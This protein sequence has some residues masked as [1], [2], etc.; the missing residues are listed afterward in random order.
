MEFFSAEDSKI[1]HA[2]V[3]PFETREEANAWCE[4]RNDAEPEGSKTFWCP[5]LVSRAG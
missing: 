2:I 1:T 4:K 3:G 5:Q